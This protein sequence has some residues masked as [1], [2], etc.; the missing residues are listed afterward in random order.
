VYFYYFVIISPWKKTSLL[1][2]LNNFE[3]FPQRCGVQSLVKIC[4]CRKSGKTDWQQAV[5]KAPLEFS[6]L[7]VS[8]KLMQNYSFGTLYL[9]EQLL[10]VF[11]PMSDK[12]QYIC[13]QCLK[14]ISFAAVS[15]KSNLTSLNHNTDRLT[16]MLYGR[17]EENS[18]QITCEWPFNLHKIT[19]WPISAV[20]RDSFEV[21]I[22]YFCDT[23]Y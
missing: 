2:H 15:S 4:F 21:S 7:K 6:A 8:C 9:Q 3:S 12:S 14:L 11:V 1:I 18:Y 17:S 20:A 19:S 13:M 16:A 22:R 5:R 10:E 23:A